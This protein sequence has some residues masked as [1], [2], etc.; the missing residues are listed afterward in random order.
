M[1]VGER[2]LHNVKL[3]PV[4]EGSKE[5]EQFWGATPAGQIELFSIEELPFE[6]GKDYYIDFLAAEPLPALAAN[7]EA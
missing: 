2:R 4:Y 3:H 1:L 7:A 6:V 5:N